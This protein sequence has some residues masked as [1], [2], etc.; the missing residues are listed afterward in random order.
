MKFV[1][2]V[3]ITAV[4]AFVLAYLLPGISI[5]NFF[6]AILVAFVLA[7]LDAVVKPVLVLFTLPATIFTLGLFLFV[8]NACI[9]LLD[10]YFVQGFKVDGFWYALLFSICLSFINSFVHKRVLKD[11][12]KKSR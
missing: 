12:E 7:L 10:D 8:I 6:T 2:K 3:L 9:I 5:N 1:A 11:E 4:N